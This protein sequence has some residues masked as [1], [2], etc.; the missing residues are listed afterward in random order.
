M[1]YKG[2][3]VKQN[4]FET[5]V[6]VLEGYEKRIFVLANAHQLRNQDQVVSLIQFPS[7]NLTISQ[8]FHLVCGALAGTG[9]F[10]E[11]ERGVA[12]VT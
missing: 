1:M 9:V 11:P 7:L 3:T 12:F 6:R 2:P 4:L 5:V 8:L 10:A